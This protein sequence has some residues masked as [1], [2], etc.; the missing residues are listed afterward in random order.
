MDTLEFARR[1]NKVVTFA[2]AA[3][4]RGK[5]R[6]RRRLSRRRRCCCWPL[7]RSVFFLVR[8][9]YYFRLLF[10]RGDLRG[11]GAPALGL[12]AEIEGGVVVLHHKHS[13]FAANAHE[14]A[15]NRPGFDALICT[16]LHRAL[17]SCSFFT[18]HLP[19]ITRIVVHTAQSRA[20]STTRSTRILDIFSPLLLCS[21]P[22]AIQWNTPALHS[23]YLLPHRVSLSHPLVNRSAAASTSHPVLPSALRDC[24]SL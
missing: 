4:S 9:C 3:R 8:L 14:N 11:V 18:Q 10:H 1:G 7:R 17:S 21:T 15:F 12:A 5:W 23:S 24:A 19:F 22:H 2:A 13:D 20:A 6:R 16:A